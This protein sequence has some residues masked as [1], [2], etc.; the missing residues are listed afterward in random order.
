MNN[1]HK[2]RLTAAIAIL[3][4]SLSGGANA[5]VLSGASSG[6]AAYVDLA[7]LADPVLSLHVSPIPMGAGG[8]APAPY[9]R[10]DE[11]RSLK[12]GDSVC[13]TSVLG[14]CTGSLGATVD[15]GLLTGQ[16]DSDVDGGVGVRSASAT[17]T[18]ND[19]AVN[20]GTGSL[21]G[22]IGTSLF[23]LSATTLSASALVSG[24]YGGF[25]ATGS[26]VIEGASLQVAGLD[27]ITLAADAAPN[28]V[29]DP[30]GALSLLGL[31]V[32]LNEQLSSC[33][34]E[35]CSI[36]VNALRLSFDDFA[37]GSALLNGDIVFGHAEAGLAASPVPV[38]AAAWL[39]G[40]GLAG[41]AGLARRG[42]RRV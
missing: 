22:L 1:P 30:L 2:G 16:A 34:A 13:L 9:S 37:L 42:R 23:S 35:T 11:V 18:V 12:A 33:G 38:P 10:Y 3:G 5:L 7:T 20:M 15:T 32:V 14:I 40:S 36:A 41:L 39:F 19:A 21:L 26:S 31:T 6:Y 24:D 25:S 17:G 8:T 29:V 28:T 27:L 4:M